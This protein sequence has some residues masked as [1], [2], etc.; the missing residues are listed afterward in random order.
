MTEKYQEM[1]KHGYGEAAGSGA[2]TCFIPKSTEIQEPTENAAGFLRWMELP[3]CFWSLQYLQN[4]TFLNSSQ[5]NIWSQL[6]LNLYVSPMF[7]VVPS[8]VII[9]R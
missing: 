1:D 9:K 2:T 5:R 6:M 3:A 7:S 4:M 8:A